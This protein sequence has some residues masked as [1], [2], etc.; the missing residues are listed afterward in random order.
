ME[1]GLKIILGS[2]VAIIVFIAIYDLC[3]LK[4]KGKK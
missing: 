2:L 1:L 4:R 3:H